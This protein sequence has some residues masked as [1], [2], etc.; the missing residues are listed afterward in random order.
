MVTSTGMVLPES[1]FEWFYDIAFP[2]AVQLANISG[3]TD[4]AAA[5]GTSNPMLPLYVGGCQCIALGMAVEVFESSVEGGRGVKGRPVISDGIPGEL[6]C[7]KSFPT[8][9]VKFLGEDG[10]AKYFSSYFEK[11]DGV[12]THGDFVMIQPCTKQFFLLGRADGVLNPSGVRFGSS[13][14]YS[15]I[16]GEFSDQVADSICVGQRRPQDQDEAVMLFLQMT[17]G[18]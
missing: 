16:D 8:M 5:F 14:I 15:V 18:E 7:T 13:D 9:P 4:I 17:P 3:G 6:V 2:P 10:A 12:W 1:L 11:Y